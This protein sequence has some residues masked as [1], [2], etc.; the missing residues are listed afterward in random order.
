MILLTRRSGHPVLINC[1]II[2]SAESAEAPDEGE[3]TA[4][5][6]VN[7]NTIVVREPL[8]EVRSRVIAFQAE[9]RA[10]GKGI[11]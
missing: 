10:G 6:L 9:V 3:L 2:E 8:G 11:A 5:T 7:G 4:I 1:E